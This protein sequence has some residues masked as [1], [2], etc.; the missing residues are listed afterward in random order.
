[1]VEAIGDYAIFLL[2]INGAIRSWNVGAKKLKG[3]SFPEVEGKHFS[4]FY[5]QEMVERQWPQHE[6]QQ[7]L[8][9]GRFED[10]GWRVRKDG[11]RFWANVIITRL[12]DEN[13]V[14]W[15]FT[16]VTRDLTER[17]EQE[18]LLRTSEERFRLLV[19]N[20]KDYAIFM[21]D[22]AGF[23]VSWNAGA[24]KNTGYSSREVIG[25]HFG[26]FYPAAQAAS[27]ALER[28]MAGALETGRF[29]DEGWR[30][31]KDGTRYW[32]GVVLTPVFDERGKHRG[33]AK[34]M[35]DLT[36]ARRIAT[37]ESESRQ[38]SSY[39]AMLGHELRNPL[40]PVV[41]A[42]A[43]LKQV[44]CDSEMARAASEVIDRQISHLTRLIDDLLDVSR[45]TSGKIR[46][47]RKP[48]PIADVI[49]QAIE[50]VQP[51]MKQKEHTLTVTARSPA[52]VSG[53]RVRLVQ[54]V[55]NLLANAAKYCPRHGRIDIS[56]VVVGES[57]EIRVKDDGVGIPAEL[58]DSV[59]D[60]FVQGEQDID[61][62]EGGLG[63]GLALC[64]Q[65]A[66]LHGGSI[67]LFSAGEPGKGSEFVVEL[68]VIVR[69]ESRLARDQRQKLVLVVD[70]N[71][72][73]ANMLSMLVASLGYRAETAYDGLA[74][75]EAIKRLGP[76]VVLLDIGLPVMN[77]REV[78]RRIAAEIIDPPKLIAISGYGQ[79]SDRAA[80]I[81]AG[82]QA[83]LTKPV[84][85]GRIASMLKTLLVEP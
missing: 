40:A 32:A 50:S 6:L 30:L 36:D 76:E 16:K 85:A 18:I 44:P 26:I 8:L 12:D 68:P 56:T 83:H 13:G 48:V 1:M 23:V 80:S 35:R 59:F 20:V 28:E 46:L 49:D 17:R 7:A 64:R 47:D 81:E 31:R 37:L 45:I 73:A 10:E 14:P 74:A 38:V 33:F 69:P 61:R 42:V 3:W 63:I 79:D 62:P 75:L 70:D 55:T 43:I 39:L 58:Q 34:V 25:Q 41:N 66:H 54:I 19:E 60:L 27:G 21:L 84:E 15:G 71:Q 2:D 53:D 51:A 29:V 11:S 72:D 57:V 22:P 77:G 67:H 78:A 24:E 4:I 9:I 82:F 5:P 65:L 52:W